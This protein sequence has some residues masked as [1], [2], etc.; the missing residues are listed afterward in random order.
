VPRHLG[1]RP[2]LL[3]LVAAAAVPFLILIG[4]ALWIQYRTAQAEALDRAH[5]EARVIAGEIDDHLGNLENLTLGLSHAVGLTPADAA[6]NDV[7]LSE[8]KAQLPSFIS[9]I[10]VATPDG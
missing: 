6:A 4:V 3:G 1:I 9:E 2:Q 8:L 5:T 7:L 10:A